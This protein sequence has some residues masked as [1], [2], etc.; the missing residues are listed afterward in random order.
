MLKNVISQGDFAVWPQ[1]AAVIFTLTFLAILAWTYRKGARGHYA[2][3][4]E[5]ALDD[6][7]TQE[8]KHGR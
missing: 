2:S 5:M 8:Q 4:A 7:N 3:M 6:P 1:A